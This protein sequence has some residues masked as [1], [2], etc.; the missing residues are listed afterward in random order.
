MFCIAP[1]SGTES[2]RINAERVSQLMTAWRQRV[3]SCRRCADEESFA[4]ASASERHIE[5][6]NGRW[7][8]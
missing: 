5:K 6:L 4:Y 7:L 1:R 2:G 3:P 8:Q